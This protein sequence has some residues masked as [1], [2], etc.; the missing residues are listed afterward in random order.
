MSDHDAL[1]SLAVPYA[2]GTATEPERRE[3]EAHLPAC[4]ACREELAEIRRV[5]EAL[6]MTTPPVAAP[7]EL[8]RTIIAAAAREPRHVAA[9][10][11]SPALPWWIAAAASLV[12]ILAGTQWWNAADRAAEL[13]AELAS[14]RERLQV[15]ESQRASAE[16]AVTD[17]SSRLAVV[18]AA[19]AV[20]VRLAGQPPSPNA[21]GR[22]IWSPTR[23]L[24]FSAANLPPLPQGRVYQLWAV[25]APAPVG[26]ALVTPD[27]GQADVITTVPAGVMPTAFAVTIEPEGGSPGPTGAMYLLGSR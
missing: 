21:T 23:G 22:V 9:A 20:A 11:R 14:I 18:A 12:A 15:A 6:A 7:D 19:D 8:R 16:R 2:M 24:V 13:A 10:T 5:N 27:G 1:R 3:F 17:A 25:A 4:A 26:V